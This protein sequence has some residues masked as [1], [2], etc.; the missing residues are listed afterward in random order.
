MVSQTYHRNKKTGAVYVYSV[1]SYWDKEKKASR[2][3]QIYQGKLD[4]ETGQLIPSKQKQ[5]SSSK[6]EKTHG[7]SAKTRVAGPSL[8]LDKL[9]EQT[10]LGII[11]KRCFPQSHSEL[12]SLVYFVVQKGLPLSRS[13]AWSMGNLHPFDAPLVSQRISELLQKIS[14]EDRQR[15]LSLW[16]A[17]MTENDFLCYDITSVSSYAQGNEYIRYGYNR[18]NETLPQINLA[19]LFGQKSRL[20]AYYRR[21]QGNISDV[22]T[23]KT[24]LK[25]MDFIG[26]N[27]M[28]FILDRGFYSQTNVDELLS[29]RHH[30]TMAIPSGRKWIE[31]EVSQHSDSIASPEHYRQ[32]N[33]NESIYTATKLYKWNGSSRR[34][35]LH[36]YYNAQRA[37]E[38][39]DRFTRKILKL[40]EELE[41]NRLVQKNEE[42]YARYFI[43][44]TTPKRGRRILLN[45]AEIQKSR[46]CYAGFFCILSTA[47]KDPMDALR[48]YRAKD[49]VENSFDD[50]KNQLD[51]KRL[52]IHSSAAMDSRLFIQ[53][54]S[55]ILVCQM[56][57]TIQNDKIL[58]NLTIREI[59]EHLETM[60]KITY[61]G[62]YGQL[63]T[64]TS[65]LQR[66]I[67]QTFGIDLPS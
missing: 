48:V 32:I 39:F 43:I 62:R 21:M 20:P 23:L 40:K 56:R 44:N 30:F 24:T 9:V 34:T 4:P 60:V 55:L 58:R 1:H 7:I 46:K 25:A 5:K 14:E 35:Y 17:K 27:K 38:D 64:E 29:N 31:A 10:G 3:K 47:F 8:L 67:M 19:M 12:L 16:L 26:A 53:F 45:E 63:Y 6:P 18:D 15:F 49:V 59:M 28:H 33:D 11:L 61:S 65:P 57:N 37:A 22:A 66:H 52:R 41:S 50:L 36:I 13:E 51:M 54:L 2:N 42:M